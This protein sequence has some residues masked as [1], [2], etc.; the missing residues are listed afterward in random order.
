[1]AILLYILVFITGVGALS[2]AAPALKAW[3]KTGFAL[4]IGMGIA[5]VYMFAIDLV[6]IPINGMGVNLFGLLLLSAALFGIYF[7]NPDN[8][9]IDPRTWIAPLRTPPRHIAFYLVVVAGIYVIWMI[10]SRAMFWPILNYDSVTGYD[11]L[12]QITFA[13]GTF[14]NS[15]FDKVNSLE[16]NRTGYAPLYPLN[17]TLAYV[18]GIENGKI[19]SVFFYVSLALAFFALLRRYTTPL[20]SALFTLLLITIPEYAFFSTLSSNNPPLAYYA[21]LGLICIYIWYDK[22]DR[23]FMYLG[24]LLLAM[25][26][27]TRNEAIFFALP[28]IGLAVMKGWRDK[29][30]RPALTIAMWSFIPLIVWQLVLKL[31]LDAQ[32]DIQVRTALFLD[33]ERLRVMKNQ[34]TEVTFSTAYYGVVNHLFCAIVLL[35]ALIWAINRKHTHWKLLAAIGVGWLLY[36]ILFYQMDVD[37]TKVGW[38]LYSYKRGLFTYLPPMVF[39]M[40]VTWISRSFFEWVEVRQSHQ[41]TSSLAT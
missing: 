21:G 22:G 26:M 29:R 38:L 34:I 11:L 12:G 18:G 31:W 23:S 1:M 35:S 39:F 5:S 16:N 27:W 8:R 3:E 20:A 33:W 10:S 17:L 19:T 6:G 9:R 7:R 37:F 4:P 25:G 28:A 24:C 41:G 36:L 32:V 40:A 2:L 14:N 13:E 15:V 30:F